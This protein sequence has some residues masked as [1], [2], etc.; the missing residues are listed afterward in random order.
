MNENASASLPGRDLVLIGAGHT[1]L[2][3][4]RM[5]RM[6]PIDDVRLT[7][8]S[9]FS[10]ATYSGMLPGTL[11]GLND[12]DA[13]EI[14]L[15]RLCESCGVRLI[16]DEVTGFDPGN[17]QVLLAD[18]PPLRY[19]VASIG[20]G[21]VP[22]KY[23]LV[24]AHPGVL[25]IKPMAT[26]RDR[27]EQRLAT[28]IA[29][30]GQAGNAPGNRE[31]DIASQTRVGPR[32]PVR[33]AIVGAGAGGVEVAFGLESQLRK[34]GIPA[35]VSLIEGGA[36]I[37]RGYAPG[38]IRKARDE[39]QRREI[40]VHSGNIVVDVR[41]PHTGVAAEL[42]FEDGSHHQA[43]IIVWATAAAPPSVLEAI[44][45]PKTDD[46]FL[47]VYPTLQTTADLPV[48]VV[49]DTASIVG[50]P[51]P[52]A[53]V[54]AVR[55]GPVL[56]DNLQRWFTGRPLRPFEPQR[57]FLSLLSTGDGRALLDYHGFSS[58]SRWAWR[59]KDY[60]D[61]K[62]M[63]MYRD[64]R[65]RS[66]SGSRAGNKSGLKLS[67]QNSPPLTMRCNGCG[68]KVGAEV[69]TAAL[70][71]LN[72]PRSPGATSGLDRP[73]D[74]VV[75]NRQAAPVDVLSV[76]FFPAFLDD[77]YLVARIAALHALSD[78]WAMGADPLGALALVTI[79]TGSPLQQTELLYQLLA[80]G[81]RELAAA[82]ASLWGGHT[83]E[84]NELTVGYN[85]AGKLGGQSPFAKGNLRPGDRLILTKSL[86]TATLLAAHA[87]CRCEARWM[88]SM[89][90]QMLES[91]AVAAR[92]AREFGVLAATDVTGFG[93]A[94]H[95]LEMLEASGVSA[96]LSLAAIPLLEGFA[97]LSA[98]GF[99]SSLDAA[100][101]RVESQIRTL[102]VAPK[103]HPGYRALFDPQT[104]GGLLIAIAE[105]QAE[106]LCTRIVVG[107]CPAAAIIGV[108]RPRADGVSL[109]IDP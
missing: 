1:H 30:K 46:G 61:R 89:L 80:G 76:D 60:I 70:K 26:F 63:R 22:G 15:W 72:P 9:S 39:L 65:P 7:L 98:A 59:L 35:E 92:I 90:A 108:V 32:E 20:I 23:D 73:E 79:P 49:G 47:A 50:Q 18:R 53:G 99:R 3:V 6:R 40:A 45:L 66:E 91:N 96:R 85:V 69:L 56:W 36:E 21:S 97:E 38:T 68:S 25:S 74:A 109:E 34:R 55:E 48:F 93:L 82:G 29:A 31:P 4:V 94:G 5:W 102:G 28:A 54:Y 101:R 8:V 12:P 106:A 57:G 87:D 42:V 13:M 62:F 10:R 86:G 11:A 77:P 107:G 58:H 78:V 67:N 27:F 24:A 43:D 33:V 37:L 52:K 64:Y 75:L 71:R 103:S 51:V 2:H 14:D 88:D 100:N 44:K 95:L 16:V 81:V 17:Q 19:D 84:G 83:T 105:H 104:S 41:T